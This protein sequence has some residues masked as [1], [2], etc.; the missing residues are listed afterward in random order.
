MS[1]NLANKSMSFTPFQCANNLADGAVIDAILHQASIPADERPCVG[2][3]G[4]G[5]VLDPVNAS[6]TETPVGDITGFLSVKVKR[7]APPSLVKAEVQKEIQCAEA[8]TGRLSRQARKDIRQQVVD[9]LNA[10][11]QDA[12][13]ETVVLADSRRNE[14]WIGSPSLD[15]IDRVCIQIADAATLVPYWMIP[16]KVMRELKPVSFH[17]QASPN[18]LFASSAWSVAEFM[19]WLFYEA[20]YHAYEHQIVADAPITFSGGDD[21]RA[22]V[23]VSNLPRNPFSSEA[24]EAIASGKI[25]TKATFVYGNQDHGAYFTLTNTG[26]LKVKL[27]SDSDAI[28]Y[29][30][31]FQENHAKVTDLLDYLTA[32]FGEFVTQRASSDFSATMHKHVESCPYFGR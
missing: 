22:K 25:I 5:S 24:H 31:R 13:K 29:R 7:E 21:G 8:A 1:L 32:R 23:T 15:V 2:V 30:S 28:D 19:M 3:S 16:P 14:V 26:H 20:F 12:Y 17:P 10:A 9:R 4:L 6:T 11:A 27:V 18:E